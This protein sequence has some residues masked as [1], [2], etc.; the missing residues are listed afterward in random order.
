M[1]SNALDVLNRSET[2]AVKQMSQDDMLHSP[3]HRVLREEQSDSALLSRNISLE[4]SRSQG[5]SSL[6]AQSQSS[7]DVPLQLVKGSRAD[8][9]VS[10]SS[11]DVP[12][13]HQELSG[14]IESKEDKMQLMDNVLMGQY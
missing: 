12:G 1:C 14:P 11:T 4:P 8:E 7:T 13:I 6:A 10:V 9:T 2:I 5:I 3:Q